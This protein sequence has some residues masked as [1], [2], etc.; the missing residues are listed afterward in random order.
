[1]APD[2]RLRLR[3]PGDALPASSIGTVPILWNNVHVG[4][5]LGTSATTILDEIA[6]LG[7]DG[8]QLGLGFPEGDK[9]GAYA[10]RMFR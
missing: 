10:L 8:T 9:L 4:E 1:M 2:M 6:R 5:L 7:Y 3:R